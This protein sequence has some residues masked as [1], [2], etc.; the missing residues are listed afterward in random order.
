MNSEAVV[1]T[2]VKFQFNP[3]VHLFF[4]NSDKIRKIPSSNSPIPHTPCP[5]PHAQCP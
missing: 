4:L 2:G 5:M 1:D 3:K